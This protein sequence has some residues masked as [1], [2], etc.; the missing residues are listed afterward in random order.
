ML[1]S[2]MFPPDAPLKEVSLDPRECKFEEVYLGIGYNHF[3]CAS[4]MSKCHLKYFLFLI[5]NS[6]HNPSDRKIRL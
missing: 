2:D 3:L 5:M 6:S 4:I 1:S